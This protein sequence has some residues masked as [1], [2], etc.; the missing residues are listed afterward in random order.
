MNAHENAVLKMSYDLEFKTNKCQ[1]LQCLF[2]GAR[3]TL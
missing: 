3:R 1:K 2:T